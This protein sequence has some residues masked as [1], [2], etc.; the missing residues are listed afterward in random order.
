MGPI[1]RHLQPYRREVAAVLA[2]VFLQSLSELYLPNL[3]ASIVDQG[4]LFGDTAHIWRVGGV[5]LLVAALGTVA[6]VVGTYYAAKVSSGYGRDV[7]ARVFAKVNEFSMHEVDELGTS[8]LITRTTNDVNQVQQT[9]NIAMRMLVSAPL[10]AV[11]GVIMAVSTD[12]RL[13][14]VI[15]VVIPLL[16]VLIGLVMRKGLPLFTALQGKVDA[17]NRVVRE[18]LMGVRVIRAFNRTDHE[19]RRFDDASRDL[20][21]TGLQVARLMALT[22]PLMM[23]VLNLTTV[24]IVWFGGLRIDGGHMQVGDL[25]AFIQYVMLIMFSLMMVS[26]MFVMLPRALVSARRIQEVLETEPIIKDP[27]LS[28]VG[29]GHGSEVG[30]GLRSGVEHGPGAASGPGT[31]LV[32]FRN[33]SFSYPGAEA[34]ALQDISFVARPGQT[35]AV[36]G[37]TGSGKTTLIQLMMRFYDATEG[38]VLLDG[39]DIREMSQHRLRS[40]FGLVPQRAV[41]FSGTVA[42]NIR[43][44]KEDASEEE[45]RRAAE[46]AQALPFVEELSDGFETM[47]EQGGANLSGGQRQRLTIARAVVRRPRVY[48]FDDSFSALDFKTDAMVR[49]ALREETRDATVFIVGQR[50]SSIMDADQIIVLHQGRAV[51][52]GRHD[53]LLQTCDVYKEI[54]ASQLDGGAAA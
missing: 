3:M 1:L 20:M 52:I 24:A 23:V 43:Y 17:L 32:E 40:A 42:D 44:G 31:G 49:R 11:G 4:I 45:V 27:V 53:E 47:V 21:T 13:S 25:M 6:A 51:G 54:V 5:M 2:F 18:R 33:V 50:V 8:T 37:G 28:E 41:L 14:L 30:A 36:I 10:M 22:M 39:V 16:A 38:E 46:I 12:P 19:R 9:V 29:L 7:R 35:T 48:V 26:M 15:V 34:A